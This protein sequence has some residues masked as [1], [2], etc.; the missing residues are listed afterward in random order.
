MPT[1]YILKKAQTYQFWKVTKQK[2]IKCSNCT[3]A[4]GVNLN[5]INVTE[6]HYDNPNLTFKNQNEL[7]PNDEHVEFNC[8]MGFQKFSLPLYRILF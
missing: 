5:H 4:M 3:M 7:E 2:L 1:D 6:R 8:I